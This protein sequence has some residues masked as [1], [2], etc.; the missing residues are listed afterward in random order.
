MRKLFADKKQVYRLREYAILEDEDGT[1]EYVAWDAKSGKVSWVRGKAIILGDALALTRITSEGEEEA[2]K[3]MKEVRKELKKLPDWG[4]KSKF[5]CAIIG[6]NACLVSYCAT[7]KPLKQ[8]DDEYKT[9]QEMLKMHG[10]ILTR[11]GDY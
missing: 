8:G 10:V 4:D 9:V 1:Y 11:G 5:Y 2:F 6:Q 7:G 3:A